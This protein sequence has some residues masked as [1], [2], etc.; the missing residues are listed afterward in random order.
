MRPGDVPEEVSRSSASEPSDHSL[1]L[2]FREGDH[3][4]A[5]QLYLRYAQRLKHLVERKCSAEQARRAGVEDIV[6]SVFGSFFRR[7]GKGL[8]NVPDGEELWKLLVVLA[9][10]KICEKAVYH[11]AAKRDRHRT[12]G[13]DEA[14]RDLELRS[15]AEDEP[16]GNLNLVLEEILEQ[17]PSENREMVRLRLE[18]YQVAEVARKTGRARRTV[19]RIL[20]ETR[21]KLRQLVHEED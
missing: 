13:G 2:R 14:W 9:L 19:E 3:D 12:I 16:E 6:Q 7:M 18:G 10:H 17:L 11:H 21:L 4:A 20:Q 15:N 8:Y 1:I 5:T